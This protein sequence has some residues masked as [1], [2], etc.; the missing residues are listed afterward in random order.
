M[1]LWSVE[2]KATMAF[3]DTFTTELFVSQKFFPAENLRQAI[4]KYKTINPDPSA[5][6]AFIDMGTPYP[7][8]LLIK[9]KN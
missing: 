1:S 9:M 3:M 5:W 4:L 7:P 8:D 2:D 6:A